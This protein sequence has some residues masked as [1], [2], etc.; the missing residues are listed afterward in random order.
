[1]FYDMDIDPGTRKRN[2]VWCGVIPNQG[3]GL[4]FATVFAFCTLHVL[5]KGL[6]TA[7]LFVAKPHFLA[8]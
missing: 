3:R 7:L 6:A 8:I 2:P 5:A 1:M 4:A